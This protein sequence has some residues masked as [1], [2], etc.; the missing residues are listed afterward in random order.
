[1]RRRGGKRA[2]LPP[3]PD[4][5]LIGADAVEHLCASAVDDPQRHLGPIKHRIDVHAK[6]PLVTLTLY[7]SQP[8]LPPSAVCHRQSWP[9]T[10]RYCL[11]SRR[12]PTSEACPNQARVRRQQCPG[13]ANAQFPAP[14]PRPSRWIRGSEWPPRSLPL[15]RFVETSNRRDNIRVSSGRRTPGWATLE[16]R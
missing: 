6:R 2:A 13:T 3:D 7:H 11:F 12:E 15:E 1:M 4:K 10:A 5:Q 16:T 14:T 8:A 9:A